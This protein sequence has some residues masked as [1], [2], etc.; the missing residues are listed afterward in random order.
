MNKKYWLPCIFLS[1]S[2]NVFSEEIRTL[3]NV[4]LKENISQGIS[5]IEQTKRKNWSFKVVNFENE[6][7]DITSSIEHF[8]PNEDKSK[9]WALLRQNGETPTQR[10]VDDFINQ[11]LERAQNKEKG[12]NFSVKLR[13]LINIESLEYQSE[14]ASHINAGFNVYLK[15]L[16][17]DAKGK[18]K[19]NLLYNKELQFIESITIVNT[20]DFS[21]MFSANISD[22]TITFDFIQ[23]DESILPHKNEMRMKGTFAYFTEIDEISTTTYSDYEK[24][25]LS[26]EQR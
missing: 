20:D 22:L 17:E 15:R 24:A 11:K 5:K 23:L 21:P 4:Q 25:E 8:T 7:G 10:Q 2:S 12:N 1:L 19:G 6:E 9:R 14:T 13:D 3:D 16:G 26:T 18:L